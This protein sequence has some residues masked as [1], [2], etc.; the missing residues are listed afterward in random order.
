[1]TIDVITQLTQCK[2]NYIFL[3]ALILGLIAKNINKY[4]LPSV[5]SNRNVRAYGFEQ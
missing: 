1:M 2:H 3:S 5:G 4:D